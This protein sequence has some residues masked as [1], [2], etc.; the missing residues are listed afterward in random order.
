MKQGQFRRGTFRRVALL[1]A[2]FALMVAMFGA[3]HALAA[4]KNGKV[5]I[6]DTTVTGGAASREAQAAA[7]AGHGVDVVSA[8]T[9]GAM[10]T[11]Q[12][13]AYDGIILGDPTCTGLGSATAAINNR[14]V[15]SAAVDG[16]MIVIGTDEVF[17]NSQG[18]QQLTTSAVKFAA[19][20]TGKTGLM[21][22]LSCYY[23]GTAPLTPIPLLDQF[24]TGFKA[25]GVGCYNDAHIVAT[26]PAL[27]GL[28]DA[29]LSNWSC[30][31]HEAI[32]DF[33]TDFLPLA[34]RSRRDR[35]RFADVP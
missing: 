6:L 33:P 11:A 26:H 7:A 24:G 9:W 10:T 13:A 27:A 25:S 23:H 5:I 3:D 17:H 12:F 8:A 1:T 21:V 30:S 34:S 16:N 22:S 19:D 15:W 35:A 29:S 20:A 28:T 31:V 2:L 4:A 14:A 32:S 18:G